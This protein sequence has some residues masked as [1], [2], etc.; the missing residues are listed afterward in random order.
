MIRIELE[1]ERPLE[2][3]TDS[4]GAI[5]P[6]RTGLVSIDLNDFRTVREFERYFQSPWSEF[7]S[8][9]PPQTTHFIWLGW[10][11]ASRDQLVGVPLHFEAALGEYCWVDALIRCVPTFEEREDKDDIPDPFDSGVQSDSPTPDQNVSTDDTQ[12]SETS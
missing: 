7:L 5:R 2:E 4:D 6:N 11:Q 8:S 1:W 10:W 3:K 9:N 12:R